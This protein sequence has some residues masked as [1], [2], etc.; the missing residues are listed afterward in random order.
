MSWPRIVAMLIVPAA[1]W[2]QPVVSARA[3]LVSY[4]EGAIWID[5]KSTHL[6]AFHSIQ[7]KDGQSIKTERNRAEVLLSPTVILRLDEATAVRMD[8]T[9]LAHTRVSIEQ[10]RALVEVI[11]LTGRNDL[12]I[13]C[14][15]SLIQ[16]A[17]PGLYL[18]AGTGLLQVY[19]GEALVSYNDKVIKANKGQSANLTATTL[20]SKFNRT[21]RDSLMLWASERSF[22]L[23]DTPGVRGKQK[24][25]RITIDGKVY[26]DNFEREFVSPVILR[27]FQQRAQERAEDERKAEAQ[28]AA[29]QAAAAAEAKRAA[30]AAEAAR[31]AAA[32]ASAAAAAAA[33]QKSAG[34]PTR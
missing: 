24:N 20:I 10:G 1:A 18:L 14:G 32:A 5:G 34:G 12:R 15:P 29:R 22:A 27:E 17:R 2:S 23:Y 7:L 4:A 13:R 28:A 30:A 11:E 19:G 6:N 3:G 31:V 9:L 16:F 8:D 25:W 26:S 33:Q 21:N